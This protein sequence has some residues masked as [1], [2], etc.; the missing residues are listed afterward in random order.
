MGKQELT[1]Q[2]QCYA[3]LRAEM[4][5]K[6]R[7]E[8]RVRREKIEAEEREARRRPSRAPEAA[9][10]ANPG[11]WPPVWFSAQERLSLERVEGSKGY[12]GTGDGLSAGNSRTRGEILSCMEFVD[13]GGVRTVGYQVVFYGETEG[14]RLFDTR[15]HEG[16]W[17]KALRAA[18]NHA[19]RVMHN[20]EGENS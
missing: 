18:R 14:D 7:A 10:R 11:R 8:E 9:R 6:Q 5:T 20:E 12:F 3:R 15:S 17:Q 4:M 2:G 19:V 13:G 16:S 1:R